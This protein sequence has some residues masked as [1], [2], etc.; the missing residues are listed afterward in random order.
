M[1]SM[2]IDICSREKEKVGGA[3]AVGSGISALK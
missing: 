3:G 1:V 2:E